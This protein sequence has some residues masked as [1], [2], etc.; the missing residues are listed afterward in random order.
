MLGVENSH[1]TNFMKLIAAGKY[2]ELDVVGVFS[3]EAEAAQ[4]LHDAFGVKI[5]TSY[6]EAV[7]Q[8]DGVIVTA[9]NGANHYKYAKPYLPS[10]V[11]MFIDKPITNCGKEAAAFMREAKKYGV[12]VCGGSVCATY[13]DTL[14]LAEAVKNKTVGEICGGHVTCPVQV[15]SEYGGFYFYSQHLVQIMTTIFGNDVKAVCATQKDT[16]VYMQAQYETYDVMGTFIGQQKT[17]YHAAVYGKS[18]Y[19]A[20]ELNAPAD[21]FSS[22]MDDIMALLHGEPMKVSYEEFIRP[23]FILNAIMK[24]VE[25]GTWAEVAPIPVEE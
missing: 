8:V 13:P 9:R 11:P 21:A 7:G 25:T 5:M 18:G 12:R 19:E 4:K 22:E 16:Q 20:R 2:P 17:Y 10:G 1:A 15:N 14:Y 23:V 24:S 3:E 6:D